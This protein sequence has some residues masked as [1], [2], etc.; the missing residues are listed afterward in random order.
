MAD[1]AF[2]VPGPIDTPTG[3]FR[4][5]KRIVEGLRARGHRVDVLELPGRY[6][7]PAPADR[8]DAS[9]RVRDAASKSP[10]VIVDGL[11]VAALSETL[12]TLDG[13][14]PLIHHRLA[15]ETGLAIADRDRLDRAERSVLGRV[16][17]VICTSRS[18]A[19]D[20][21]DLGLAAGVHVVV[22]GTDPA[23]APSATGKTSNSVSLLSVGSLTPRKG[24]DLLIDALASLTRLDW[25]LDIVGGAEQDP[26]T[27][28]AL[29]D[30]VR[31]NGLDDRIRLHGAVAP[32]TLAS[33]YR[34]AD[35]FALASRHEGYGMVYAEAIAHGLP[36]LGTAAG[37]IPEV[38]PAT[39][40]LLV[41]PDDVAALRTALAEVLSDAGLRARLAAGAKAAGATL[42]TWDTQAALFAE[43]LGLE[44]ARG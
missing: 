38:V 13:I 30:R 15:L 10:T 21:R 8:N 18:T 27:A 6:P 31:A 14:V 32:E 35:L 42:P 26:A 7:T 17:R 36:V 3:G 9:R 43:A 12:T 25:T 20:L 23:G 22:P 37:A 1:L 40:G 33:H 29:A 34:R 28:A 2:I 16:E 4:Y 5:D 19:A 41:P 39:A 24:H 44:P 11:A